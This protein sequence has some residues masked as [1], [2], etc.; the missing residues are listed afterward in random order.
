MIRVIFHALGFAATVVLFAF[1]LF[2]GLQVKGI[3]Y[4]TSLSVFV[5]RRVP[6]SE[7]QTSSISDIAYRKP[8]ISS[9]LSAEY[10]SVLSQCFPYNPL[11][12]L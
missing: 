12:N 1:S 3:T 7:R 4:L 9:L 10:S 6:Y 5:E 2:L 8:R 11:S